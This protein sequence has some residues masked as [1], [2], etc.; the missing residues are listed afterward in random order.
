MKT[1]NNLRALPVVAGVVLVTFLTTLLTG[2][3][4]AP[5]TRRPD[6]ER[7]ER[8]VEIIKKYETMH[9]PRHWPL[10]GY[11]HMV[12]KGEKFSRTRTLSE[13]E[14]DALLRKDLLKNC[15]PFRHLGSDSLLLGMLAYNIGSGK[16][17]NSTLYKRLASGDRNIRDLYMSY[18]KYRGKTH[19]G[20]TNRR[21]EE[22]ELAFIEDS[23]THNAKTTA[24]KQTSKR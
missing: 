20:L 21:L 24:K 10:V 5:G 6:A 3:G 18:N 22:Y 16:V 9:S 23:A 7:F 8:A 11:G 14:A 17:K 2:A 19:K 13:A 15:A 1:L 4:K 12:M